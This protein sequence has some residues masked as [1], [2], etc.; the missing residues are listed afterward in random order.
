MTYRDDNVFLLHMRDDAEKLIDLLENRNE[1][2]LL[3]DWVIQYAARKAIEVVGEAANRV[4]ADTRARYP[5]IPWRDII[6]M[7]NQLTHGYDTLDINVIWRTAHEDFPPL[8]ARLNEILDQ[9]SVDGD[10]E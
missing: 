5:D 7:R 10:H 2:D 1:S 6:D 9:M 4:S 8:L 3:N